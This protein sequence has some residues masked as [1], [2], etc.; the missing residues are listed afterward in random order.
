MSYNS[1]IFIDRLISTVVFVVAISFF[2]FFIYMIVDDNSELSD[3][4][5]LIIST[6]IIATLLGIGLSKDIFFISIF[7]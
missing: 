1:L 4:K 5:K 6:I 3:L 7:S 2:T